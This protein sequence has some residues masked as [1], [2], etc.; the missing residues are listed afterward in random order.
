[1]SI[2]PVPAPPHVWRFFRAGGFDQVRLESGGDIVSL[3]DLDQK[4][5]V[6][7]A[8]PTRGLE[9]D[10]ATLDLIDA[11]HDGRIRAPEVLAA[12]A[13]VAP[14]LKNPDDLIDGGPTLRLDA[15]DEA[16]PA[17]AKLV[18]SARTILRLLGR[19]DAD[20]ISLDDAADVERAFAGSVFNGDGVITTEAAQTPELGAVIGEIIEVMGAVVDRSGKPGLTQA[21][22]DRF[23]AEAAAFVAWYGRQ[24]G[25]V[26]ESLG[27]PA[28]EAAILVH[29]L[30]AKLDDYFTRCRLAAFDPGAAVAL[31]PDPA[32][33]AGFA[34]E[35]VDAATAALA[36]LPLARVEAGRPLPLAEG[37]NPAWQAD[38]AR[39]REIVAMPLSGSAEALSDAQWETLKSEFAQWQ[40][41]VAEEPDTAVK[42]LGVERLRAILDSDAAAQIAA[43]VA[44]D[45]ALAPEID[46][47]GEVEKLIRLRRDLFPLLNNFVAFRD[48]YTRAGK[49]VFQAGTLY[50]DGRSLDLC[51][52]VE[53]E[54]KHA[55]IAVLSGIYLAYCRCTR[56]GEIMTIAAAVTGGDSDSIRVG[57]NGVFYDRKG[58]DWDASVVKIVEH[59]IGLR[60]AFWLP[61]K[62]AARMVSTAI[63]KFAAARQ[64]NLKLDGLDKALSSGVA[65]PKAAA[66]AA[67]AADP[68]PPFDVA[69]YAGIFAAVGLA[70]GALATAAASIVTGL[71]HLAAWQMPLV[72]IGL[73]LAVSGPSMLIAAMKLSARNLG[74]ILDAS[75]WAVN[76]RLKIN[77][78][79]G[80]ALTALAKLPPGAQ[81]SL[82]D[83]YAEKE[84]PWRFYLGLIGLIIVAG[85]LW[86]T[87]AL[88]MLFG[89]P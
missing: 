3:A 31:N 72:L 14:L 71:L 68:P 79:F 65:A 76:T 2:I 34:D 80:T 69:K 43:L 20:E 40:S 24:D 52:R 55:Q 85:L 64:T 54:V 38:L 1:M 5:W 59:P 21:T 84:T 87:G 15:I 51:V 88:R 12:C 74:P 75:G 27:D 39:F 42:A 45:L 63:Q 50:L 73:I 16:V 10:E 70:F 48:F 83:P 25:Q 32:L 78:P 26:S 61:Y 9:F 86:H 56:P 6:A 8:C 62:Q 33:Y 17:G 67:A 19:H 57:R 44:K 7:L 11:D 89:H 22:A 23:F 81:R 28:P 60:Q 37:V 53:D 41:W 29:R 49:A 4:L 58:R 35:T 82:A 13:W 18:A 77:I 66:A 36:A 47:I 30:A 46:A